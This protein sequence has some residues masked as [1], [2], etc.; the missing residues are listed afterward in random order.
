MSRWGYRLGNGVTRASWRDGAAVRS[1]RG[2]GG[3]PRGL[4]GDDAGRRAAELLDRTPPP[5]SGRSAG[6]KRFMKA[7]PEVVTFVALRIRSAG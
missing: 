7:S 1:P 4:C 6:I 3:H 5:P 2:L